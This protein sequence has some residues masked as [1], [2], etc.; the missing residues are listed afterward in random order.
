MSKIH[1]LDLEDVACYHVVSRTLDRRLLF[2]HPRNAAV[3]E[4]TLQ[5]VRKER[6]Y[7]LGYAIMPDHFH[8]LLVPRPPHSLSGLLQTIKGYT[9]RMINRRSGTS[10]PLWQRSFF[11]R[12]IREEA[13]LL[14][15]VEY[16]HANPV[17]AGLVDDVEAYPWSSAGSEA[18]SDLQ[19]WLF[20]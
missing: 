18:K 2:A 17:R 5:F 4:D 16:I 10:G 19:E 12:L 9:S 8:A 15:T 1:R 20:G 7:L 13:Q 11:D 3:L 14:A 6:A